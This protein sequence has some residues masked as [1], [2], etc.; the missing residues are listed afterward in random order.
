MIR[1][2]TMFTALLLIALS[3][4]AAAQLQFN[5][6]S[7]DGSA[8]PDISV[9]F[10][11]KDG[12]GNSIIQ[13]QPS[14][15]TV[16]ENGIVRPV[17][18]VSCPPPV[19][20][21]V[22]I[23]FT[24]D[25]SFS[26]S[27]DNRLMN[28]QDASTQLV[29]DMSYPPAAS[30][31][32]S[33]DDDSR[34]LTPY[35]SNKPAIL[36]T[37]AGLTAS[38]GGTDFQGAFLDA[39]TGAI[40]VTKNRSGDK[41]IVFM[42]DAFQNLTTAIEN[43]II[44][45]ARAADIKVYTVTVSPNT[46]NMSLRR[47]A[48][49]T[50]GRWFEDVL[51]A[52]QAKSIFDQIGNEIFIYPPCTLVYET[53]GCDT[54]RSVTVSLRKLGRTETRNTTVSIDPADI[55]SLD[56]NIPLLDFGQVPAGQTRNDNIVLRAQGATIRVTSITTTESAFR[57]TDYG[58]SAPPFDLAAGQS[59]TLRIQFRPVVTDRIVAK[60]EIVSDA[61]CG[62]SSAL[63]GGVH[64]PSPLR[65]IQPNGG[66]KLFSG[67][68][69]RT[70][71]TGIS[72]TQ[73]AELE[74]STN[75]G[76]TWTSISDNVYNFVYNWRV[77]DTPS[78]ECLGFVI[79][80]EERITSL[81]D[82]W[83]GLQPAEVNDI[84][85]AASGTL[86][87]AALDNGQVKLFYPKDAAFVTIID[88]HS[89]GCNAVAFSPDLRWLATGGDD[90][91]VRIWNTRTGTLVQELTGHS[92][93]VHSVQFSADGS[94]LASGSTN[95]VI[96]WKTWDWT[97]AWTNSADT[98]GDGA[99]A[100]SPNNDFVASASG[101]AI[102][103]LD[104]NGGNRLRRLTGHGGTVRALD[105]SDDGLLIVSGADDRSV[106]MWNTLTWEQA[107]VLNGH[108]GAVYSVAFSNGAGRIISA[109]ADN[110]V[111][112]WDGRDGALLHTFTGHNASVRSASFDRRTRLVLSGGDDRS[113]RAWGYVPPLGDKSDSLFTI[114]T[115]V[116]DLKGLPPLFDD[117]QCPD[118]WSDGVARFVNTG[119]QDITLSGLRITGTD[120]AAFEI[121]G[122]FS[123]PPDVL[124]K[125]E[126]TL[127]VPLRFFP[128]RIGDFD[129]V[130]ELDTD[131]PGNPLVTL[132]LAGHKDTVRTVVSPDTLDAGE[133][134]ACALPVELELIMSNAGDVNAVIDS[135]DSDL[136]ATVSF[137]G[138]F[139][140]T[141]LPGQQDT[142][143]VLVHPTALGAFEGYVRMETT[144][145]G[146]VEDVI[147]RGRMVPTALVAT[148]NPVVFDFAAVGDTS[149]ARLVL[150]N[151]TV[152]NMV[153]DSLAFLIT[154]PPF[155]VLDSAAWLDSLALPDTLAPGDSIVFRLAYFPRSEG[156]A[157]GA[158]F[159]HTSFP[160]KDSLL[161]PL[162]ASSARKPQIGYSATDFP[163]LLCPDEQTSS[164]TA[165][166]RNT[167]GLALTVS[168]LSISGVNPG[169]F[170][171]LSPSTPLTIDPGGS[172]TV[173]LAFDYQAVGE[174][175]T[176][177]LVI[178][179]NAE[180]EPRVE[181]PLA[182][183][184]DSA[185]VVWSVGDHSFGELYECEFPQTVTYRFTNTGT[186]DTD[187]SLDVSA[188]PDG[189]TPDAVTTFTLAPQSDRS[190]TVTLLPTTYGAY[191]AD[192]AYTAQPCEQG[193]ALTSISYS[194]APHAPEVS[195]LSVDFGTLGIGGSG[196]ATV[197]VRNPQSRPMRVQWTPPAHTNLSI[198]SPV[199]T[200]T[201]LAGGESFDIILRMDAIS[202]G[203]LS[204]I[205]RLF[206]EQACPDSATVTIA[207]RVDAA[208][209][210]LSVPVLEGEIGSRIS[211]P[212]RLD[213]AVNL[214]L[215]G[216]RSFTAD[217]VF[218]RSMLWPEEIS[219]STGNA[220]YTTAADPDGSLRVSVTVTQ[221]SSPSP[222]VLAEL[223]CLVM[224]GNNDSTPLTLA[225][226]RWTEGIASAVT[227]N[228]SFTA[229]GICEAGGQRL[230][231]L[232]AG[233]ALFPNTPNPF[234]PTTEI[235]FF[236]PQDG[237]ADLRVY[238]MLGREV[239]LLARGRFA[240]GVHTVIFDASGLQ[241]GS[242]FA[243][244]RSGA[245][246]RVRRMILMK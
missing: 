162:T 146:A 99:V 244:L 3:A 119:N 107:R 31:V 195:P 82:V 46:V 4:S 134:Y 183:R 57:I 21:P 191:T 9:V 1:M 102:A 217:L 23:T 71:W 116:T 13:Y 5:I 218:N 38:G 90:A 224:L 118:T 159:F 7:T 61:P 130:L 125:P 78:E 73:A 169:D 236:M 212:I 128:A 136:G 203:D 225:S 220:S 188:V 233:L 167:G 68:T 127:R 86:T 117:L 230:M 137:P 198:V 85:V 189:F 174:D 231:A 89:N 98:H 62:E 196:T 11:A 54:E 165:T 126:D 148:P 242:Y 41:Y 132:P 88:A 235:A 120:A 20:P 97:R 45:A 55:V 221:T 238:D 204:D 156:D 232:P 168:R 75:S 114:I 178:E 33:F 2:H 205:L 92:G 112:V 10:E 144:P 48:N 25:V 222:G 143:R 182:A 51:T 8:Y 81:D 200:D 149:Y 36:S 151:P 135:I 70:E 15:F 122:G 193:D 210:A 173:Q 74:Y 161:V 234:N 93:G 64:D 37:I 131:V 16:V 197:T 18:S 190:F 166:L 17:K 44:T 172:E 106:R 123:I 53:D 138:A 40:D 19:T 209:S 96:L 245:D 180:N 184:K 223:Q 186:V 59:R 109:A 76:S 199:T 27:I 239:A 52:Q 219:S 121:T 215:T 104:F 241:S 142:V 213:D 34:I 43:Q 111:R 124:M 147:I 171:I 29:T 141:L 170:S 192:L 140:R 158:L 177:L 145:C 67:T 152:T 179:S 115:T 194:Y 202:D 240:A 201:T 227:T 163:A 175:R 63:A 181:I 157:S 113:I 243:V 176:A 228:G 108:T 58:G 69:F 153:F 91:R 72:G 95:N 160:C 164:A 103:I 24:F 30:A 226:F 154:T 87:A 129:A 39:V 56:T 185:N 208:T 94:F 216:T 155:A 35:T 214:A 133:M 50:G 139:P 105:V 32:T 14:D 246:T 80:R 12:A 65:L 207:G 47:I 66:E 100:I 22:S 229:T 150:H 49:R 28:L 42:T 77:P 6:V 26:M 83:E 187:V 206:T 60:L 237:D 84:A 211:I 79:T 110:R 101:N